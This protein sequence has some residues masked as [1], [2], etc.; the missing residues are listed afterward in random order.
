[1][2]RRFVSEA[3]SQDSSATLDPSARKARVFVVTGLDGSGK[4]THAQR[5]KR[6]VEKR[7][8]VADTLKIY[9]SGAFL[10][11][12]DELG[13][14]TR[15]GAPLAAFRSSRIV[16]LL[17]SLRTLRDSLE[18]ALEHCDALVMDRYVE[19]H[20]AAAQSQLG[21]NLRHHPL[22]SAFPVADLT[23]WLKL[24]PEI[25]L[26]RLRGRGEKLTADE[27]EVGL[28]G[29]ARLFD[30]L[31]NEDEDL[32]LD[33]SAPE[34]ENAATILERALGDWEPSAS[35]S[36]GQREGVTPAPPRT[37]LQEPLEVVVGAG[38]EGQ[39]L[40]S[41]VFELRSYLEGKIG[42]QLCQEI[43]ESFW[44]EGYCAQLV[45]DL[46]IG[47]G[48][49][50][51]IPLWP[52]ALAR[53]ELFRDLPMLEELARLLRPLVKIDVWSLGEEEVESAFRDLGASFGGARRLG[54]AYGRQLRAIAE[55]EGWKQV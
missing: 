9:R 46:W 13:A 24:A 7:E 33:A 23:V 29:Y 38:V 28:E 11:L 21:W 32:T 27:H 45:L 40:G 53:M 52:A 14:R 36:P 15:R 43:P 26:E 47:A 50:P 6:Q 35:R 16:K 34:E 19:T 30:E 42:V 39:A 17:D 22:L 1:L 54:L 4:T 51:W 20:V 18:P 41:D 10:E 8:G 49:S 12:A 25:A 31:R 48:P 44:L 55:E 3:T 2:E 37:V 5:L